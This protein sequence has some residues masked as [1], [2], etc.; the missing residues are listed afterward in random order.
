M[1]KRIITEAVDLE[2]AFLSDALPV[3]LI[4]INSGTM[5][6]YIE[7]VSDRLLVALG[8]DKH[9]HTSNPFEWMDLISLEGK[10]N[11]FVSTTVYSDVM[12]GFQPLG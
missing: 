1:V 11:F 7:F 5:A 2:K 9:Y 10:T 4:G 12:D 3:D 8:L 6:A